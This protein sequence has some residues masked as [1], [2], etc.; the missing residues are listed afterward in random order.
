MKTKTVL[1]FLAVILFVGTSVQAFAQTQSEM[2][3][4]ACN[5]LKIADA[6][7]NR[8][9]QQVLAAKAA[10]AE[11]AKAFR[12]AQRAWIS[13]RDAHVRSI[14]PDP[15]PRAYGS[16]YTMCRCGVLD[17]IT[18]QRAKE[19]Q[20]LWI[21]GLDEGDVCTGSCVVKRPKSSPNRR[22]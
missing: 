21:D 20:Q 6:E 13:F 1:P 18:T 15:D 3:A 12:E 2:N 10:D 19:M 9:Y 11:F 22:E 16:V 14:F 5:K 17:Q 8:I 7:L 4:E